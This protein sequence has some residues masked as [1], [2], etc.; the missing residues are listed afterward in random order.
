MMKIHSHLHSF[1]AEEQIYLEEIWQLDKKGAF[2]N[3]VERTKGMI[4]FK[5]EI[6]SVEFFLE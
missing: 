5:D 1:P 3:S 4:I 6:L 2:I